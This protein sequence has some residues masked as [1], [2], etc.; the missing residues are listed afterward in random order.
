MEG[1][2]DGYDLGVIILEP[3]QSAGGS[4]TFAPFTP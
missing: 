2:P 4:M 3:G 1:D